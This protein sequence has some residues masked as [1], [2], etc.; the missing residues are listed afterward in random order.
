MAASF[1]C[2]LGLPSTVLHALIITAVYFVV[3]L[4]LEGHWGIWKEWSIHGGGEKG[5]LL[6]E[7]FEKSTGSSGK[8]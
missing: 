1:H 3:V 2:H 5:I 4:K 6:W 8:S 7:H